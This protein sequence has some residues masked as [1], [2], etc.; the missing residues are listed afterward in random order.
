MKSRKISKFDLN[1][2]YNYEY[3]LLLFYWAD[4]RNSNPEMAFILSTTV[5]LRLQTQRSPWRDQLSRTLNVTTRRDSTSIIHAT[6]IPPKGDD[7]ASRKV[8]ESLLQDAQKFR[9]RRST[10]T[11]ETAQG[12]GKIQS[13]INTILVWDFF[14]ICLLLG[15]L[16]IAVIFH[17]GAKSELLLDPWLAIWPNVTQPLLG[18]LMLAAISQGISSYFSKNN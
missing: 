16:G 7:D 18:V 5:P 2:I 13:V 15:W 1:R 9:A 11:E 14:V 4:L 17:Y 6:N 8:N 10:K 12:G 3:P